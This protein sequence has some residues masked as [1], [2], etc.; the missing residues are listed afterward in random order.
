MREYLFAPME[1]ITLSWFRMVH[2]SMFPGATEYYMPFIAPDRNGGFRT[3]YLKELSIDSGELRVIPQLLVNHAGAFNATADRLAELGFPEINLNAGCPSG[4]VFSKHKGAGMLTDPAELDA[5][6]DQIF[7]HAEQAGYGVSIKTRM[8]V[9]KSGEFPKILEVY[10]RYPVRKLIIHARCRDDYY[11]GFPD[12]TGFAE[13]AKN[14]HF[15]VTYNGNIASAEDIRQL[16]AAAPQVDSVMIGRAAVANPALFR[17]LQGGEQ[18]RIE[19][20][21]LFHDRLT[22]AWLKTGL[23]PAFTVERMKTIW[24]YMLA[25]FPNSK[26]EARGIFKAKKLEDYCGA[27]NILLQSGEFSPD[28]ISLERT[29]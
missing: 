19:E 25:M 9:H 27:V 29:R 28:N 24:Q 4:T 10:N 18:L 13:A 26:R 14:C 2:H 1:G 15:P 12:L 20:L 5:V 16:S 3:K 21:K 6:L 22:E 8:G 23:S 11:E 7:D 17:F